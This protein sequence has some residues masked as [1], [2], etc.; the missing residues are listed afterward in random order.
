[1]YIALISKSKRSICHRTTFYSIFNMRVTPAQQD[2]QIKLPKTRLNI[3]YCPTL[4]HTLPDN[5]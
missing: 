1:M 3:L 4:L 2:A 5:E